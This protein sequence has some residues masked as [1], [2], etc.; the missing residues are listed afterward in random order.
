M[1]YQMLYNLT[2]KKKKKALQAK[3]CCYKGGSDKIKE[4]N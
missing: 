4:Q 3:K 2:K 1:L